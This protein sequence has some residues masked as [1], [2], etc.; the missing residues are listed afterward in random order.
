M[1]Y[2]ILLALDQAR[3]R[4]TELLTEATT[5]QADLLVRTGL[6]PEPVPEPR[7]IY[8]TRLD[9][10]NFAPLRPGQQAA[11]A[12]TTT[13]ELIVVCEVV[14]FDV[15]AQDAVRLDVLKLVHTVSTV[16]DRPGTPLGG[17]FATRLSQVR[18]DGPYTLA[19]GWQHRI[20]ARVTLTATTT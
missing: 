8:V 3:L 11:F 13:A 17:A 12:R 19:D 5:D 10:A 6:P 20:F 1:S 2:D 4:L 7:R 9:P 15:D 14:S 16:V 18:E